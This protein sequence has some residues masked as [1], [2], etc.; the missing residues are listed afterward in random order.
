MATIAMATA[1]LQDRSVLDAFHSTYV[2]V[3]ST[4][5]RTGTYSFRVQYNYNFQ[6][7]FSEINEVYVRIALLQTGSRSLVLFRNICT[8]QCTLYIAPGLVYAYYGAGITYLG[9]AATNNPQDT[10]NVYEIYFKGGFSDGIITVKVNGIQV[11]HL[12]GVRTAVSAEAITCN[13]IYPGNASSIFS[14]WDDIVVDDT[15]WPG[16]GGIEVLHPDGDGTDQ[17]WDSGT[18]ADVDENPPDDDTTF[19]AT[20]AEVAAKQSFTLPSPSGHT[21]VRAGLLTKSRLDGEGSGIIRPYMG[22]NQGAEFGLSTSYRWS[23]DFWDAP[24]LADV[25]VEVIV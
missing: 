18:Y 3:S 4:Y 8:V 7:S 6:L 20:D 12:T 16:L 24:T 21:P 2:T 19:I 5:A 25:G 15:N 10:W 22:V 11:L 14:Y 17:E 1:D 13:N 9:G 23:E